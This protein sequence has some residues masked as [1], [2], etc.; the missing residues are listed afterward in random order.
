MNYRDITVVIP[1]FKRPD[2]LLRT[3]DYFE[4]NGF[5]GYL[6]IGDSSAEPVR[7]R[8]SDFLR[9]NRIDNVGYF[10]CENLDAIDTLSFL[11]Q[12]VS[13]KYVAFCG[14]DDYLVPS[15]IERCI[16]FLDHNADYSCAGGRMITYTLS[17]YDAG[18]DTHEGTL[19]NFWEYYIPSI[20]HTTADERLA[21]LSIHNPLI[22]YSVFRNE[23]R[24]PSFNYGHLSGKDASLVTELIPNFC[25]LISGKLKSFDHL[26]AFRQKG[27]QHLTNSHYKDG[28]PPQIIDWI[29]T[30]KFNESFRFYEE[31]ATTL[32]A[33][34]DQVSELDAR[35]AVKKHFQASCAAHLLFPAFNVYRDPLPWS[36]DHEELRQCFRSVSEATD[37][38]IP[39][40][41]MQREEDES[42]ERPRILL[43]TQRWNGGSPEG[44]T[45]MSS[46]SLHEALQACDRLD[47]TVLYTD[48]IWHDSGKSADECVSEIMQT[49][50]LHAVVISSQVECNPLRKSTI[51]FLQHSNV[52]V[53]VLWDGAVD[54]FRKNYYKECGHNFV[55]VEGENG[56]PDQIRLWPAV[57]P[58]TFHDPG[59]VRDQD[60]YSLCDSLEQEAA[61][62]AITRLV[63]AGI[64]LH[65]IQDWRFE[66]FIKNGRS[67]TEAAGF[68]SSLFDEAF[69]LGTYGI[70]L[71]SGMDA[72]THYMQIGW[73]LDYN[74]DPLFDTAYYRARHPECEAEGTNPLLHFGNTPACW[75]CHPHPCFDSLYYL[76]RY[77]D[78]A[79]SGMNPLD[80]Y[81][82][83]GVA[84]GRRTMAPL[85]RN[86]YARQLKRSKVALN[87]PDEQTPPQTAARRAFEALSCGALLLEPESSQLSCWFTPMVDYV[88]YRDHD[89]LVEKVRHY[90]NK[91]G[92]RE[93]VARSGQQK[94]AET[95][96]GRELWQRIS[97]KI[98]PFAQHDMETVNAKR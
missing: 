78:V 2:Y 86:E 63:Q 69:Y 43:V 96:S 61:T 23:S 3:I 84:E 91:D 66:Q 65:G 97:E 22:T 38:T 46:W 48:Q 93:R 42:T 12:K 88:P 45:A 35:A 1:T 47:G 19:T 76:A 24:A 70:Q 31:L 55:T 13:T 68:K 77:P 79:G 11:M 53:A 6:L 41:S 9:D 8:V 52:P 26:H 49:S 15:S 73:K 28:L 21:Y 5:K 60:V 39:Q 62:G 72:W 74:P 56:L 87:L 25:S 57:A 50:P 36:P 32:F 67:L 40:Q 54:D 17:G 85:G 14:D 4:S 89:D 81:L 64:A 75:G 92:E 18:K 30:P 27:A 98:V 7:K 94:A 83:I 51:S 71:P 90:L 34:A 10:N 95:Y 29:L 37:R 16:D 59:F 82:Q 58:R 20:E 44:G 33:R 80:H